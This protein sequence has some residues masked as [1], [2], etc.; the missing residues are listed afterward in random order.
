MINL[1]QQKYN[2]FQ[3]SVQVVL[4]LNLGLVIP[5]DDSVRLLS[6]IIDN[7]SVKRFVVGQNTRRSARTLL[8][9]L[10][11]GYMNKTYSSRQIE[12]LC[13]RDINFM[14]LLNGEKAPDHNTIARF[15]QKFSTEIAD[16]FNQIV[17]GLA[18]TGEIDFKNVFIDGTKIEANANRYSF[19]WKGTNDKLIEKQFAKIES[20]VNH[21]SSAYC[22]KLVF[23]RPQATAL[24]TCIQS[25]LEG[26][27]AMNRL[28]LVFGKGKHKTAL[29]K[30]YEFCCD[31]FEKQKKYNIY[32]AT[33]G[34]RR[35]FSK[36]DK[37]ATFMRMKEDH[38]KNGQ[39]KPAYNVQLAVNSGYIVGN[40][41]CP[42]RNDA[43]ALIPFLKTLSRSLRKKFFNVVADAGYES[44]EVYAFLQENGYSA[45]IKPQNY[46]TRKTKAYK[47]QIGKRENMTFD[48]ENDV[49][50]CHNGRKLSSVG[51]TQRIT[52]GGYKQLATI[53]R[54]ESC[55]NC[56]M[57][58]KC[59]KAKG[60][61]TLEVSKKFEAL[62]ENSYLNITSQKGTE[63]RMNRSIQSEGAFA[64]IKEDYGFRRFMLRG[65]K[66]ITTE[67]NLL[68]LAYNITKLHI[69]I[70][71]CRLETHLYPL[72]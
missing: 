65:M 64:V 67:I 37:D 43:G 40:M 58:N 59:T 31:L 33:F 9:L 48:A 25:F 70:Q 5:D 62:R 14:W 13:K 35:S 39:L 4:P 66:N 36:T 32:D 44:E 60:E 52:A 27:I 50:I 72:K 38:M 53:Y 6:H 11:Y 2:S 30:D 61:K 12:T 23:E 69:K 8:K 42:E 19:V 21:M 54:C 56:P 18:E 45:Y 51:Q 41:T 63:L 26:L 10:V 20:F 24:L 15:R 55:S 49:Y 47:R 22:L 34:N 29:Q 71:D 17:N 46:E 68:S 57:K 16:V 1:T 28:E 7:I 3:E